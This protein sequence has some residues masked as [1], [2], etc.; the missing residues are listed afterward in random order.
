[1]LSFFQY[2]AIYDHCPEAYVMIEDINTTKVT[3]RSQGL[4]ADTPLEATSYENESIVEWWK[5]SH[6]AKELRRE[7][8]PKEVYGAQERSCSR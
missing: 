8:I 1:M 3:C 6:C 5:E 4:R 2:H 7:P